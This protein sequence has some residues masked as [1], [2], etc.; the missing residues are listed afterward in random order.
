MKHLSMEEYIR[1]I[2]N[3]PDGTISLFLGA[4]ASIQSGVPICR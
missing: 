4:G 2:E 1:A 3:I